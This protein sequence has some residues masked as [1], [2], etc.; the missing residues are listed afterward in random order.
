MTLNLLNHL[1]S[2]YMNLC[3][4]ISMAMMNLLYPIM[5]FSPVIPFLIG[6]L[7]FLIGSKIKDTQKRFIIQRSLALMPLFWVAIG[8]WGG[9]FRQGDHYQTRPSYIGFVVYIIVL[10]FIIYCWN[11]LKLNRDNRALIILFIVINSYFILA[12]SL[13]ALMAISGTWL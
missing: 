8:S 4:F 5:P 1:A 6:F 11:F 12:I 10:I 9:I 7:P 3:W 2:I 13:Y